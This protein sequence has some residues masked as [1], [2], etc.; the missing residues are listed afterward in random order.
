MTAVFDFKQRIKL[1][2]NP[3]VLVESALIIEKLIPMFLFFKW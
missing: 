3:A 2:A 1:F